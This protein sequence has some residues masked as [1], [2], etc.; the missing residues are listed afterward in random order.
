MQIQAI[1]LFFNLSSLSTVTLRH[2]LAHAKLSF[3][4]LFLNIL[5]KLLSHEVDSLTEI[6]EIWT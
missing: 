2:H 1:Y 4:G 5:A 3:A 6:F